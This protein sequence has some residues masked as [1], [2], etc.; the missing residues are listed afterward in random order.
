MQSSRYD[1]G[2]VHPRLLGGLEADPDR[3]QSLADLVVELA[4]DVP[5]LLLL[6]LDQPAREVRQPDPRRLDLLEELRLPQG[7]R[8]LIGHL[9]GHLDLLGREGGRA[10][11]AE[12]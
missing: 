12:E 3:G 9:A 10:V 2:G 8:Q 4:C 5:P 6:D 11:R 1:V 7:D